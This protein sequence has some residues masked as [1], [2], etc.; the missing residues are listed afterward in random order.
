MRRQLSLSAAL[1]ALALGCASGGGPEPVPDAGVDPV[2]RTDTAAAA[3]GPA[4][5]TA[6]QA[7][8]GAE[9]YDDVCLECHTRVE[10]TENAFLFGWEGASVARLLSYMM[11]NMPDD[12]PGSLPERSYLDVTAYILAQN[13]WAPGSAELEGDLEALRQI[14]F[15]SRGSSAP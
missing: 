8:R 10:F 4:I 3:A 13:G 12:A 15:E 2:D 6:G 1:S 14:S 7:E 9:V 11:E 5:F